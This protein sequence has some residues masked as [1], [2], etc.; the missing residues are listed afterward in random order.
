MQSVL[1][2]V[3]DENFSL[4]K[5]PVWSCPALLKEHLSD[6]WINAAEVIQSTQ[7]AIK[8]FDDVFGK[9]VKHSPSL[10]YLDD[11]LRDVIN[12]AINDVLRDWSRENNGV[13]NKTFT[14]RDLPNEF[15]VFAEL[16]ERDPG[17]DVRCGLVSPVEFVKTQLDRI[18]YHALTNFLADSTGVLESAG[19]NEAAVALRQILGNYSDFKLV[20]KGRWFE[21]TLPHYFR[22]G[23]YDHG[24]NQRISK[25]SPLLLI[26]ER[27][28]GVQGLGCSISAIYSA[29]SNCGYDEQI[30][31]R[32][33]IN[34]GMPIEGVAM[35][36]KIKLRMG[37]VEAE[38]L[39]SFIKIHG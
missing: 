12:H 20:K 3:S 21:C 19:L 18:N 2:L 17:Y 4:T 11:A 5:Q 6:A 32:T 37:I 30:P 16:D 34:E 31:L 26:V 9:V 13:S 15:N 24:D 14:V 28:T 22:G 36:D 7:H 39:S 29:Y 10:P 27:E 8:M 33:V 38:A 35:R 25:L 1:Q 23:Y